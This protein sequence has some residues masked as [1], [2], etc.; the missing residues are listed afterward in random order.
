[1]KLHLYDHVPV[2]WS[3]IIFPFIQLLFDAAMLNHAHVRNV[4]LINM[5]KLTTL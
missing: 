5:K 2:F 1:M 4:M 3:G